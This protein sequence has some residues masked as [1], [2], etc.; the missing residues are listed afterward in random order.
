MTNYIIIEIGKTYPDKKSLKIEGNT[1]TSE[2]K[3]HINDK[4]SKIHDIYFDS[5][6]GFIVSNNDIVYNIE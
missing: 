1:D 2:I 3:V 5:P 6:S 4:I